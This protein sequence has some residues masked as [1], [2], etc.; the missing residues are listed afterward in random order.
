MHG[1]YYTGIPKIANL[2]KKSL[3]MIFLGP[4]C[5]FGGPDIWLYPNLHDRNTCL[6]QIA[7]IINN[8]CPK[9]KCRESFW[10]VLLPYSLWPRRKNCMFVITNAVIYFSGTHIFLSQLVISVDSGRLNSLHFQCYSSNSHDNKNVNSK[11][12]FDFFWKINVCNKKIVFSSTPV[13]YMLPAR[14]L[15]FAVM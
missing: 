13:F 12:K 9:A 15:V 5:N 1:T 10:K 11:Q 4:T 14:T 2:P 6:Q 8:N 3:E 7:K